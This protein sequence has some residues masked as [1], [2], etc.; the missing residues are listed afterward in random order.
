MPDRGSVVFLGTPDFAVAT[1]RALVESGE[2]VS[3][4][5]TQPDRPRGRS[6]D[7]Q[8]PPVKVFALQ[9]GLEVAQPESV[10]KPE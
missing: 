2:R 9:H 4:V 1:L 8:P 10:R 3:L 7:P 5:V 6:R